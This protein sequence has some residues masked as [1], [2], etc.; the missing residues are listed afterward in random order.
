MGLVLKN[1]PV[2]I[3]LRI[4]EFATVLYN[5]LLAKWNLNANT[6][7]VFGRAYRNQT[8]DGYI[9]EVFMGKD[10]R[11]VFIDDKVSAT[12]FFGTKETYKM[13][14]AG[15][16][17]VEVFCIVMTNLDKIKLVGQ[18]QDEET[19]LDVEL[20][21]NKGLYGFQPTSTMTGLDTV[22]S[23][24]SGWRKKDGIKY[25]DQHPFYNFRL[26]FNVTYK[27]NNKCGI[28]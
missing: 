18:R 25:R 12:V 15:Y 2:G 6:L 7:N 24:Y 4:S 14:S 22:F 20:I 11:D 26:N 1:N 27:L 28:N 19:K 5:H 3:D 23:E 9:P 21:A 8:V 13:D 17:T 10:Y 16:D